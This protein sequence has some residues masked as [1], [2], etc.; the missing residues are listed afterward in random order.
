MLKMK[1][2]SET[3]KIFFIY[4][5]FRNFR[6]WTEQKSC[7]SHN[8]FIFTIDVKIRLIIISLQCV[9]ILP[10]YVYITQYILSNAWMQMA[11]PRLPLIFLRTFFAAT[12][13]SF[14]YVIF[15]GSTQDLWKKRPS[16]RKTKIRKLIYISCFFSLV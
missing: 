4:K 10:N 6:I 1:K 8:F 12:F 16:F 15:L 14:V 3:T 9:F 5:T 7:C 2:S 11:Y 13:S